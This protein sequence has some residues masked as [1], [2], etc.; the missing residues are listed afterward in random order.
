MA[1]KSRRQARKARKVAEQIENA[2]AY[3]WIDAFNIWVGQADVNDNDAFF[4]SNGDGKIHRHPR[5]S[6]AYLK[7]FNKEI[8]FYE[9]FSA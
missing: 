4:S 2:R 6:A 8:K 1:I 7:Q 3:A 9:S 5:V